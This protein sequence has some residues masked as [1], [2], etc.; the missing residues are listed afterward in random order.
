MECEKGRAEV[1]GTFSARA[2]RE[3]DKQYG[4]CGCGS[5]ALGAGRRVLSATVT[6]RSA[7]YTKEGH[8]T[9]LLPCSALAPYTVQCTHE[10]MRNRTWCFIHSFIHQ[11]IQQLHSARADRARTVKRE[12][13]HT[14]CT[15]LFSQVSRTRLRL[16]LLRLSCFR[17]R[18]A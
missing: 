11:F 4:A 17:R 14:R 1:L 3:D 7:P 13:H 16:L 8:N 9:R 18:P 12:S 2:H 5:H 15:S 6:L 10:H